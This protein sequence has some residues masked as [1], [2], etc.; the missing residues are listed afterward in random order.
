MYGM[1]TIGILLLFG[2]IGLI[3]NLVGTYNTFVRLFNNIDKS[4]SKY[5]CH[6]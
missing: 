1:I 2:V 4:W 3:A 6:S 5:R